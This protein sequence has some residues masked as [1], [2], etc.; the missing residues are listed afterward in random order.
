[1][2]MR[3]WHYEDYAQYTNEE[4][5]QNKQADPFWPVAALE[6]VGKAAINAGAT[7]IV[8]PLNDISKY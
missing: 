8:N 2:I 4:I 6:E 5:K 1:M 7:I 3:A